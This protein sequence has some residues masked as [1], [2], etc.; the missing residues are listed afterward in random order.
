MMHIMC[1][2]RK[3]ICDNNQKYIKIRKQNVTFFNNDLVN[4]IE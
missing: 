2:M 3:V 4:K 1:T